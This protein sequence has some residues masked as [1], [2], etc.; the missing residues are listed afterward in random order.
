M[1]RHAA[2]AAAA[3]A[4]LLGAA[5]AVADES[6]TTLTF[7]ETNKGS[8]FKF[9]DTPP[10]SRPGH[11]GPSAGDVFVIQ[12]PL[13]TATGARRGTLRATCTFASSRAAVCYGVFAFKEGQI[14]A[15]V[16]TRNINQSTTTGI[17]IGGTGAYAGARGAFTSTTTKT[18]ANDAITLSG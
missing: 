15:L 18:G 2:V 8:T 7:K 11:R 16:S 13:V 14:A 9:V 1:L 17:V 10:R 3:A 12:N 5:P 4:A 6:P